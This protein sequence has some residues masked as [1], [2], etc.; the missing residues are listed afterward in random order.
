MCGIKLRNLSLSA[1]FL[2]V[3]LTIPGASGRKLGAE[4]DGTEL[5]IECAKDGP[6]AGIPGIYAMNSNGAVQLVI[7]DGGDPVWGP[8]HRKFCY[9]LF[10]EQIWLADLDLK[11]VQPVAK[12]G[13]LLNRFPDFWEPRSRLSTMAW[14]PD[15]TG[16]LYWYPM[17]VGLLLEDDECSVDAFMLILRRF[18]PDGSQAGF[19][20][21]QPPRGSAIGRVTFDSMGKG[22]AFET[23]RPL[24]AFGWRDRDVYVRRTPEEKPLALSLP[25]QAKGLLNPLWEPGSS[26][27]AVDYLDQYGRRYCVVGNLD[28]AKQWQRVPLPG[29]RYQ[30][31]IEC[32]AGLEWAPSGE[33]FLIEVFPVGRHGDRV[34]VVNV[35]PGRE[36]HLEYFLPGHKGSLQVRWSPTGKRVAILHAGQRLETERAAINVY[37]LEQDHDVDE[38]GMLSHRSY[39][40]VRLPEGLRPVSIDW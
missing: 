19:F 2:V 24:P 29:L 15:G 40:I 30:E 35:A 13:T 3:A 34:A 11:I 39:R 14:L 28:S 1:F 23:A 18:T 16:I 36:P 32:I 38:Y 37:D 20:L 7:R 4:L 26:R 12:Y 10:G 22:Y 25:F 33:R 21:R 5:L 27:L 9:S 17:S 8:D 31:K 6:A